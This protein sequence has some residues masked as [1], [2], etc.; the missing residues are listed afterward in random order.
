LC[1]C[2]HNTPAPAT[3]VTVVPLT[4]SEA[5]PPHSVVTE[6]ANKEDTHVVI[7]IELPRQREAQVMRCSNEL[8]CFQKLTG[9]C[10]NGYTGGQTLNAGSDKAGMLFK[11]ISDEEKAATKLAED[12]QAAEMKAYLEAA[13]QAARATQQEVQHS[14]KK[15]SPKKK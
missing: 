10:P 3:T 8:D 1:A 9:F 7:N 5:M 12:R 15:S 6:S 14:Q 4:A 13:Q 2:S 11:C